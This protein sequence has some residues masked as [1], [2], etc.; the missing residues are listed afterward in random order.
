MELDISGLSNLYN[1][2]YHW[3]NSRIYNVIFDRINYLISGK[4]GIADSI[5][6]TFA[7]IR[8]DSCTSFCIEKN[9]FS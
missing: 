7:R 2:V 4:S 3:I 1:E 8:I 6:H 5:N 9:D